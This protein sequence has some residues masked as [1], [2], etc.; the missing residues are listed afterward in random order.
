M[1]RCDVVVAAEGIDGLDVKCGDGFADCSLDR[2][3]QVGTYL[4]GGLDDRQTVFEE[5][6]GGLIVFP[7]LCGLLCHHVVGIRLV[8]VLDG[9]SIH[10]AA[11]LLQEDVDRTTVEDQVMHIHHQIDLLLS[12]HDFKAI[13]RSMAQVE[14]FHKLVLILCQFFLTH[15]L[16]RNLHSLLFVNGLHDTLFSVSKVNGHLRML[17]HKGFDSLGQG[18][19]VSMLREGNLVGYVIERCLRIFQTVKINSSLSIT[20]WDRGE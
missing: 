7:T 8:F 11:Q 20:Q 4:R 19:G 9:L 5:L 6:R 1:S 3:G 14:G 16:D 15:L 2:I 17:L 18:S 13:E 12:R 10:D